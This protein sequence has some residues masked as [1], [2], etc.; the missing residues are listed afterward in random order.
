MIRQKV[1]KE[2]FENFIKSYGR[3]LEPHAVTMC[4]PP[5]IQ[6]FDVDKIVAMKKLYEDG[7]YRE[8]YVSAGEEMDNEYYIEID[9]EK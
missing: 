9:G 6:F 3:E 7:G 8:A 2:E 5:T 1:T 4:E